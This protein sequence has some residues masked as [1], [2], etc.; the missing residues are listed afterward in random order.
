[1]RYNLKDSHQA[2]AASG[3][4]TSLIAQDKVIEVNVVKENRTNAQNRAMHKYFELLATE[5]NDAGLSMLKFLKPG[6]EIPWSSDSVKD[7]IWRPIQK[8]QL[9]KEST[10]KLT[11]SEVSQVYE[12]LNRHLGEKFKVHVPF[13]SYD[14][15]EGE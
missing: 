8:A 1:M 12:T 3:H 2:R 9:D 10:T 15:P 13:P 11:T 4:L 7:F 5:L 14:V 6:A